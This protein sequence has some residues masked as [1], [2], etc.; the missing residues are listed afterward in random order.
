M[1]IAKYF[2]ILCGLVYFG[3][4]TF[5]C[6]MPDRVSEFYGFGLQGLDAKTELR[7]IGGLNMGIGVLFVY[8][9]L[10]AID[11]K[12]ILFAL[13][14]LMCCLVLSRCYGLFVDGYDQPITIKELIF[15]LIVLVAA[16][17]FYW[18]GSD[19]GS[20]SGGQARDAHN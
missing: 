8:F 7:A 1:R 4:G 9:A 6:L 5:V 10:T 3:F 19:A 17:G 16:V 12:P 18:R 11:Q 15:E 13:A 14:V 20:H 2:I